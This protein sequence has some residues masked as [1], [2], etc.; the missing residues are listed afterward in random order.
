MDDL[1]TSILDMLELQDT[2]SAE[3]KAEILV[4][5]KELVRGFKKFKEA[6][7]TMDDDARDTAVLKFGHKLFQLGQ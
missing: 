5:G 4:K 1:S 2:E 3:G 7:K 6:I